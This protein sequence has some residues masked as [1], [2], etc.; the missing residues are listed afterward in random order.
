MQ[1]TTRHADL[2]TIADMLKDQQ[3]RALDVV[4]TAESVHANGGKIVVT[5]TEAELTDNGVTQVD[6]W[7]TP[8]TV[9][10]EGVATKLGIPTGYLK[11]LADTRTDLYDA[12]VNGLLHGG[13]TVNGNAEL[14]V[15]GDPRKFMLRLFRGTGEQGVARAF[16]SDSYKRIDNLDILTSALEGISLAGIDV[17]VMNA[18]LTDR[19]MV[20]RVR[21]PGVSALAPELLSGYRSPF[22]GETGDDNP[23]VDAGFTI[24]NS[25]TGGG[26]F[27]LTPY[28]VARV[29]TNGMTITKDAERNVHLGGKLDTGVIQ[30]SSET[31]KAALAVIRSKTTDAVKTF[32]SSDYLESAVERI[33][34]SAG[35]PLAKPEEEVK[36]LGKSMNLSTD[37]IDAVFAQFIKGGQLTIGGVANALTAHAQTVDS[38]DEQLDLELAASRLLGV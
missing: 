18:D 7:Y 38:G 9:F 8:T 26:A 23:V 25:E 12:N 13:S 14:A 24:T 31:L 29:C 37:Q 33:S 22:T 30:W 20:V 3:A 15:D 10:H 1:T 2:A 17:E 4:A 35:I 5:G 11:R 27:A 19:R 6:G 32:L 28:V 34:R 36:A 21:C 16:L